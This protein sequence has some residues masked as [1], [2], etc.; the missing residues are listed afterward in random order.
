MRRGQLKDL[1]RAQPLFPPRSGSRGRNSAYIRPSIGRD[2]PHD[3]IPRSG[4]QPGRAKPGAT[5]AK[6]QTNMLMRTDDTVRRH[7]LHWAHEVY[8]RMEVRLCD[9]RM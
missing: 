8:R 7:L 5:W 6:Q 4:W 3:E 9:R 1:L 2:L